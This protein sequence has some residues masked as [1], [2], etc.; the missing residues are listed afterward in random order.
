[1]HARPFNQQARAVKDNN[2]RTNTHLAERAN[3]AGMGE[4]LDELRQPVEL[5]TS[6]SGRFQRLSVHNTQERIGGADHLTDSH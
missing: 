3:D 1:M 6:L 4:H 5:K 2:D